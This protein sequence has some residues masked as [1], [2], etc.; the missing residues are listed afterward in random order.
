MVKLCVLPKTN[1]RNK[2]LADLLRFLCDAFL[3]WCSVAIWWCK[4]KVGGH[5]CPEMYSIRAIARI[6]KN[7]EPCP[8]SVLHTN[9]YAILIVIRF[10]QLLVGLYKNICILYITYFAIYTDKKLY[11]KHVVL[12]V[13]PRAIKMFF[14]R[15]NTCFCFPTYF[16][17]VSSPPTVSS[18][19]FQL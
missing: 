12:D 14:L 18:S 13:N 16:G 4:I 15:F 6:Y 8:K 1:K 5:P 3:L 19:V 2:Q 9:K 7:T 11:T 17:A 10:C